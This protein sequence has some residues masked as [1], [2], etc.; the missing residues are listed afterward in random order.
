MNEILLIIYVCF[1]S[2]IGAT[3]LD[4]AKIFSGRSKLLLF[5]IGFGVG[6]SMIIIQMFL[7][8]W[9]GIAW[10][11]EVLFGPWLLWL[12]LYG[13]A[14]R[15]KISH[16]SIS[17]PKGS[18]EKV[19]LVL[20]V[21][22]FCYA[23]I[24]SQLR[25]VI[26]WDAVAT[27]FMTGKGFFI[28]GGIR[29]EFYRYLQ[30]QDNPPGMGLILSSFYVLIGKVDDQVTLLFFTVFYG[31]LLCAFLSL[32]SEKMPLRY[33]LFF[34]FLFASTQE[35][36]RQAGR[37]EAGYADL[38]LAYFFFVSTCLSLEYF[39]KRNFRSIVVVS[40]LSAVPIFIKNEGS[41]MYIILAFLWL[42]SLKKTKNLFALV[43]G[44][45]LFAFWNVFKLNQ[46]LQL[47]YLFKGSLDLTRT[48]AIFSGVMSEF[49]N[50]SRW[51]LLWIAFFILIF[52]FKKTKE[53]VLL[54]L[55]IFLQLWVYILIYFI[56]PL[57]PAA[58]IIGSFDRLLLH[59][60]PL[61]MFFI[62]LTSY[63]I[64]IRPKLF[65]AKSK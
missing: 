63:D 23:A 34:T 25:P 41:T 45:T 32:L 36:L 46:G 15:G 14:K 6:V 54:L 10:S 51:N 48:T 13:I 58:Q 65:D 38:P 12:V 30:I 37:F 7:F 40:F 42:S 16:L 50:I 55:I 20:L 11:R 22:L 24:E 47:S 43:T 3:I 33:S 9:L 53:N 61:V 21:I 62:A 19:L 39:G 64:L 52:L 5:S 49:I 1:L 4:I 17:L 18:I 56:T 27:W 60:M 57:N 28:D 8:S 2:L 44:F 29:P 31:M 59:L 35:L 26:G